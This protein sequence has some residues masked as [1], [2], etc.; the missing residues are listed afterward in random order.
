MAITIIYS[1]RIGDVI[2]GAV[3]LITCDKCKIACTGIHFVISGV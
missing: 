1:M 2:S 3:G